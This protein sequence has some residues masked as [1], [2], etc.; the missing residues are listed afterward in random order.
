MRVSLVRVI[1]GGPLSCG[2]AVDGLN[3]DTDLDGARIG[4]LRKYRAEAWQRRTSCQPKSSIDT[5]LEGG[6]NSVAWETST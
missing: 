6:L 1:R 4:A 2:I 5:A 3:R